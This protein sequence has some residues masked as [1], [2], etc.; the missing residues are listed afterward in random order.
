[1]N[2]FFTSADP[3]ECA[4]ALDDKRLV[5]MAVESAQMLSTAV[6][7]HGGKPSYKVAWKN[8][9]CTLWTAETRSNFM[10]HVQLL[11]HMGLEF[12]YRYGK[13]HKSAELAMRFAEQSHVVPD[14]P[15]TTFPNCSLRKDLADVFEAY[16][17]GFRTKWS[18]DKRPPRWTNRT[19]PTWWK[20]HI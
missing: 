15:L 10:W 11:I 2:I 14:G 17:E 9:P 4:R 3:K 13:K 12:E 7:I 18:Q 20:N 5:K 16:K 1:M 8:H 19:P 6:A